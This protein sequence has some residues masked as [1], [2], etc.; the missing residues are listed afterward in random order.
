MSAQQ[1]LPDDA[2]ALLLALL[3]DPL[4]CYRADTAALERALALT[5]GAMHGRRAPCPVLASLEATRAAICA[6]LEVRRKLDAQAAQDAAHRPIAAQQS[7]AQGGTK[8]PTNPPRP[9]P[10][11]PVRLPE[12][13][14]AL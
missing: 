11:P 14:D 1:P 4:A 5:P 8:V 6:V 13:A 3:A 12:P 7:S 10:L 2:P 9:G